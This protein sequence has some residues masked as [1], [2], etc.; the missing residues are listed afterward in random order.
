M[1]TEFQKQIIK[2]KTTITYIYAYFEREKERET[3]SNL[4]LTKLTVAFTD[5]QGK[6]S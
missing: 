2:R 1:T 6:Y 3:L 4:S 5:A